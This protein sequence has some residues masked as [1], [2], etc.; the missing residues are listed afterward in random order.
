MC[1][2]Q[3]SFLTILGWSWCF[4]CTQGD[5]GGGGGGRG[6]GQGGARGGS[7]ELLEGQGWREAEACDMESDGEE[8]ETAGANTESDKK[9][10]SKR[11]K[12]K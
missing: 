2:L 12:T 11:I 10:R 9:V 4:C 5:W 1:S 6:W 3:G 8:E 7:F